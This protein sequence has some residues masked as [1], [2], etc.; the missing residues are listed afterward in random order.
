MIGGGDDEAVALRCPLRFSDLPF[1]VRECADFFRCD[2]E[3]PDACV[4]VVMIDDDGVV[5]VFFF[6]LL[7]SGRF[8]RSNEGDLF[9]VGRPFECGDFRRDWKEKRGT[10][11]RE[12]SAASSR[13]SRRKCTGGPGE[14]RRPSSKCAANYLRPLAVR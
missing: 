6:F 8:V 10:C 1:S 5:L 13:F 2:V 14:P 9:A 4:L 11:R 3:D 12:T 7:R